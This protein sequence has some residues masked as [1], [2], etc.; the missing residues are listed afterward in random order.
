MST[1]ATSFYLGPTPPPAPGVYPGSSKAWLLRE[2]QQAYLFQNQAI[3][4]GQSSIAVQLERIRTASYP[5]GVSFAIW[6]AA[7]PGAFQVDVQTADL[8][9][10]SQFV[11]IASLTGGLNASNVGRVELPSFWAKFARVK[12]VSI[13]N[14]VNSSV[15]VTR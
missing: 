12:L 15:L 3:T 10:D 6:F 8:D 14:A 2:N 7:N 5:W 11:T 1:Q 13:G 9:Q 4:A